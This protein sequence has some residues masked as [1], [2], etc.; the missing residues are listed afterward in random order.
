MQSSRFDKLRIPQKRCKPI[1]QVLD[2][3]WQVRDYFEGQFQP[4]ALEGNWIMSNDLVRLACEQACDDRG[5]FDAAQFGD[6]FLRLADSVDAG[7]LR[8]R[9]IRAILAGRSDIVVVNKNGQRFQVLGGVPSATDGHRGERVRGLKKADAP[10]P[11]NRISIVI[12]GTKHEMDSDPS[13]L[14]RVVFYED[15]R[16]LAGFPYDSSPRIWLDSLP[17]LPFAPGHSH[18]CRGGEVFHATLST[19]GERREPRKM[20]TIKI[21]GQSCDFEA[22]ERYRKELTYQEIVK[23]AG[24]D[25][26]PDV[27]YSRKNGK[28]TD[29]LVSGETICCNGGESIEVGKYKTPA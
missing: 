29:L 5:F 8:F 10:P 14:K 26:L 16:A 23:L 22:D 15:I 3:A 18:F 17:K 27:R 19:P 9:V 21:N 24:C 11:P 4:S 25:G 13:S 6:A 2:T 12:N 20:I 1:F 28:F 7:P